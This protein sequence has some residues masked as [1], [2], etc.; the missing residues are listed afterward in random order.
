MHV[1]C[2]LKNLLLVLALTLGACASNP[3]KNLDH[4]AVTFTENA[5]PD[6]LR[7][8]PSESES[9]RRSW[10][11]DLA[12]HVAERVAP[13]LS[14][15]EQLAVQITLIERA[16]G[17]EPWR[18]MQSDSVRIVRDIYPPRIELSFTLTNATGQIM[19]T[20]T[21]QLRDPGFMMGLNRYQNDPLRYEKKLLDDWI[22][23][24]FPRHAIAS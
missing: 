4:V 14:D 18:G 12:K 13:L 10:Q 9:S 20:A 5:V 24:E 7:N 2:R 6:S 23:K 21:R 15:N 3:P 19:K 17:F 1:S 8:A 22:N 16:G 11:K